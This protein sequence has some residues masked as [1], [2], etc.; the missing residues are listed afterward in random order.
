MKPRAYDQEFPLTR[1]Y[2]SVTAGNAAQ[3]AIG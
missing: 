1:S 3:G 2:A